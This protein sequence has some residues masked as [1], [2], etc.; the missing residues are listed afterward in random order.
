VSDLNLKGRTVGILVAPGYD[1]SQVVRLEAILRDMGATVE[2]ISPGETLPPGVAGIRGSLLKPTIEL[3]RVAASSLD[4]L[5]IPSGNSTA[6]L[7]SDARALTL[8]LEIQSLEKPIGT[9][10]NGALVLASAGLV[11]GK[12]VTGD[13]RIKTALEYNG[14]SY[15]DK[16]LVVYHNLV[17]SQSEKNL[18]H[19]VDTIAFLLETA[20]SLR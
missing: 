5:I 2:V 16:S 13:Y 12:R 18:H 3:A 9:I 1:D 17:T 19:F 7:Q 4:A 20:A 8:L 11:S 6:A 15:T 10:G 14:A